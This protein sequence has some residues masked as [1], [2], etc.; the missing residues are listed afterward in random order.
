MNATWEAHN[1][2]IVGVKNKWRYVSAKTHVVKLYGRQADGAPFFHLMGIYVCL[3]FCPN[4]IDFLLMLFY[5]VSPG[6]C[7]KEFVIN[8]ISFFFIVPLSPY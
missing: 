8:F 2:Q 7:V 1:F 6:Y 4:E 5:T 3:K